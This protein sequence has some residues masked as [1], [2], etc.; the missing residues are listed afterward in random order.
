[1]LIPNTVV[2]VKDFFEAIN[3]LSVGNIWS[4][5]LR[6]QTVRPC[7]SNLVWSFKSSSH[8][9]PFARLYLC[10][11]ATLHLCNFATLQLCNF[12]TLHFCNFVTLHLLTLQLC[13][14][15]T[16][17]LCHY[18]PLHFC[19]IVC[20]FIPSPVRVGTL[21]TEVAGTSIEASF[22]EFELKPNGKW[23]G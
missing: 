5:I 16:L 2:G 18:A 23:E 11:F 1:M 14:C 19:T 13:N 4:K 15:A 3:F 22:F 12:P 10:K 17:Q 21:L 7:V 6:S 20:V 9:C 8:L